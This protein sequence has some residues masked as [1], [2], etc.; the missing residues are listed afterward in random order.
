MHFKKGSLQ[1]SV[2]ETSFV[3][4]HFNLNLVQTLNYWVAFC[5]IKIQFDY[6]F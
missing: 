6:Y 2:P 5:K 1:G 4:V 3:I